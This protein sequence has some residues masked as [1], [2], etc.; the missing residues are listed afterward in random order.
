MREKNL[1]L[2]SQKVFT[3]DMRHTKG[4]QVQPPNLFEHSVYPFAQACVANSKAS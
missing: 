4:I 1:V 2:D 3:R